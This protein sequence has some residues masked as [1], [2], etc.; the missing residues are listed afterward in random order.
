MMDTFLIT[1]ASRS[2]AE[3]REK[4]GNNG[5]LLGMSVAVTVLV[6]SGMIGEQHDVKRFMS[7]CDSFL[8]VML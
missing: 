2:D 5:V 6:V 3:D 8:D 1:P 4:G 7:A